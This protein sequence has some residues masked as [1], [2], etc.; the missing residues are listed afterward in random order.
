MGAG[1]MATK[2]RLGLRQVR[3]L[4]LAAADVVANRSA[5]LLGMEIRGKVVFLRA[6]A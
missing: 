5:A 1:L 3:A 6:T 2:Q 4:M